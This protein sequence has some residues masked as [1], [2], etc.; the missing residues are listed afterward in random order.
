MLIAAAIAMTGCRG[1]GD[2]ATPTNA[3]DLSAGVRAALLAE[4]QPVTLKNCTLKRYGGA[5]DGGY[6]MCENLMSP[7]V[8]A[9]SYGIDR[10]DNWGCQ[11]S[12]QFKIPVEEYDCFTPHR[13]SPCSGGQL[14]FHDECVGARTETKEGELFDSLEMQIAKNG[15][16]GKPLLVKMDVEGAEWDSLFTAPDAVLEQ[17][18][19]LPMELHGSDE[20]FLE[21][22][23]RLKRHFHLVNLHFNNW[24]CTAATAPLP[25]HAFQVLWVNKRLG[26]VDPTAPVPAPMSPL[27]APDAVGSPD[28]QL[29]TA[30]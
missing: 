29:P 26:E 20:R 17:I 23:R 10:E 12:Q 5:N 2:R 16:A 1:N 21:L 13:P 8:A 18:D 11:I 30:R 15:H 7:P 28:C 4:L 14:N 22:V 27:N 9:Y 3:F 6:L 25:A 24:A 19:Q